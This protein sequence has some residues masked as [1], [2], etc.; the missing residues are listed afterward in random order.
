MKQHS[1]GIVATNKRANLFLRDPDRLARILKDPQRPVQIIFAGKAHPQD[2][3][4][5]HAVPH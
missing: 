3:A 1:I 5:I 4:G 2:D